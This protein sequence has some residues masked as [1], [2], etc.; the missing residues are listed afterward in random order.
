VKIGGNSIFN[1]FQGVLNKCTITALGDA[2]LENKV[3]VKIQ[4][5][6]HKESLVDVFCE[7]NEKFVYE[8]KT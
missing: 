7:K 2:K 1:S 4:F 3:C 8:L 6:G 5:S